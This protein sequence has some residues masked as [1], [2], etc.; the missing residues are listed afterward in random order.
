MF[1]N[2]S[3]DLGRVSRRILKSGQEYADGDLE[4]C[5]LQMWPALDNTSRR[6]YKGAVGKR[7]KRFLHHSA[8][9]VSWMAT[10]N[11]IDIRTNGANLF[12]LFYTEC[13]NCIVH[14]GGDIPIIKWDTSGTVL[15]GIQGSFGEIG[16]I[17][18]EDYLLALV[19]SVV[20]APENANWTGGEGHCFKTRF[21]NFSVSDLW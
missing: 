21:G 6:R 12:E 2:N 16:H 11:I 13:R 19:V 17:I 18:P 7:I 9:M 20:I 3:N 10:G 5:A 1:N 14:E 15:M 8:P 4:S